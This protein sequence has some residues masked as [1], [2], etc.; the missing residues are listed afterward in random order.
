MASKKIEKIRAKRTKRVRA[1]MFGT[2]GKPRLSLFRSAN[3]IYVQAID[4]GLKKT[5]AEASTLSKDLRE[6]LS[7]MK[8]VDQA[9]EVGKFVSKRLQAIGIERVVFDRGRYLYHGR[10]KALA[11]AARE[12]GL[13]F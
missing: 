2:D 6:K 5:L 7:G 3:H 9:R 10:V 13:K 8:K 12:A 4:D 11:E 1:R